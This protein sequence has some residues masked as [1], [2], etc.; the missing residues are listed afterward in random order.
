M[1]PLTPFALALALFGSATA[2]AHDDATLDAMPSPHGG[3]VRMSGP[4]HFELVVGQNQ[5]EVYLTDHAMTPVPS[6]GVRGSAIV[7]SG[8]KASIPLAPAG[9]NRL[10]GQGSFQAAP[11]MKVVVSLRFPDD[12]QWQARFTPWER[13][14][15]TGATAAPAPMEHA[16]H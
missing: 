10:Q 9:D 3:Q 5:L 14:H 2:Q 11:E 16:H 8:D 1:K 4:Y 13:M 15:S 12:Q 6:T 7:L